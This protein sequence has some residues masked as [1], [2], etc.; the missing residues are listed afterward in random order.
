MIKYE[1]APSWLDLETR[2]KYDLTSDKTIGKHK[3]DLSNLDLK[4]I[5]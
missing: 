2:K 1:S 5:V 4:S 3:Y